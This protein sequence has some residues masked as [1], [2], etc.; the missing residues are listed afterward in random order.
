MTNS[1]IIEKMARKICR[2]GI[3]GPRQHLD[4]QENNHWRKFELEAK[5][6]LAC[7][8]EELTGID[9]VLESCL[10]LIYHPHEPKLENKVSATVEAAIAKLKELKEAV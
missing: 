4:E 6:A 5:A 10:P 3:C 1:D 8:L 2:A 7:V 9:E